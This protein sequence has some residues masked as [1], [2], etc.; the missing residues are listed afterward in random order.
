MPKHNENILDR[1][2]RMTYKNQTEYTRQA[3]IC[4]R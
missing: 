2:V 4:K 3:E 1:L